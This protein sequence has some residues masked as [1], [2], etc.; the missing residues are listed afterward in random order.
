MMNHLP[1]D[2]LNPQSYIKQGPHVA[3]PGLSSQTRYLRRFRLWRRRNSKRSF[4]HTEL[5]LCLSTCKSL[6]H[7]GTL[8]LSRYYI[9]PFKR[10]NGAYQVQV[11][12]CVSCAPREKKEMCSKTCTSFAFQLWVW[13]ALCLR[14]PTPGSY[15]WKVKKHAGRDLWWWGTCRHSTDRGEAHAGHQWLATVAA[16]HL[17]PRQAQLRKWMK[18]E[19]HTVD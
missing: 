1:N 10:K 19:E 16:L 8:Q 15:G 12:W 4:G 7:H 11:G 5:R 18:E 6:I 13:R 2:L 3:V 9:E 14:L 17:P